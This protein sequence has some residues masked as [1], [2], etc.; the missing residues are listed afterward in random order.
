MAKYRCYD[1]NGEGV[2]EY[3]Q[4]FEEEYDEQ[5]NDLGTLDDKAYTDYLR[6]ITATKTHNG[7]FSI[8]KKTKRLVDPVTGKRSS[9]TDDV[10]AY[11][12]ILKNK[13]RSIPCI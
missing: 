9:E 11:D 3:A 5:V 2:G 10:D 4:M 12:L 8:D 7:Y 6:G 13:E 1:E